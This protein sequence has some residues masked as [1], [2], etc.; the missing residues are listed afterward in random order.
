MSQTAW[1]RRGAELEQSEAQHGALVIQEAER[2]AALAAEFALF[3]LRI[4]PIDLGEDELTPVKTADAGYR[5]ATS[6]NKP[7]ANDTTASRQFP[8][9]ER[10]GLHIDPRLPVQIIKGFDWL[11]VAFAAEI[12]AR[13]GA[14]AGLANLNIG[15]G[16]IFLASAVCLK[17]GMW[18][19]ESYR[20]TPANAHA[21][22]GLGGL[23]LGAILG[24]IIANAFAPDA[25]SAG[26]LSASLPL[27]AMGMAGVHAAL[28][29]WTRAAHR[30][31]VFAETVLLVGATDAATRLAE[32]AAKTGDARIVAVVD[33]RLAR[34]PRLVSGV[35]VSGD[36]EAALAWEGLAHVDRIV[37]TVTQK[38]E[39][40]VRD[41]IERLRVVPNRVD[42]LMDFQNQAVRGR[43]FDR[44]GGAAV[45]C[46]S[47]RPHNGRRALI[48]RAQDLLLGAL[49]ASLLAPLLLTITIALKLE[50]GGPVF[51]RER[52]HG[53]N[54]RN[55][56]VL[57]FRTTRQGRLTRVGAFLTRARLDE[58]PAILNV[59]G[60]DM[61]LVGPRPHAIGLK[62]EHRNFSQIIA[63]YAYRHRVKPGIFGWA[64]L[65]GAHG[66]MRTPAQVRK[67]VRLDLEYVSRASLWFDLQIVLRTV[68]LLLRTPR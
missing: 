7:P 59:L 54:N 1:Q 3:G 12:A 63:E 15:A 20:A 23:T 37:I 17:V 61:S 46:I 30:K 34:A 13:W 47:G 6:D 49:L 21:E 27:I 40:R 8:K 4:G 29:V 19:T 5:L 18:L 35:M 44:L 42:L 60:G 65:N 52:R 62:A 48:K 16:V 2:L 28:A 33:D 58:L 31:G 45:A 36:L 68:P 53:L 10:R 56:D 26:A 43:G 51:T 14:G 24:I 57:H 66:P 39:T 55:I 25:R 64:E 22:R 9:L 50:D 32:R 41:I 11:A 38:A 67:R